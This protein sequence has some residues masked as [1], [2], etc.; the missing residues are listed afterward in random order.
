MVA[1]LIDAEVLKADLARL[2]S[3]F[4]KVKDIPCRTGHLTSLDAVE[5]KIA[6]LPDASE[7]ILAEV[8]RLQARVEALE[9]T[10]KDILAKEE[11]T[12]TCSFAKKMNACHEFGEA[13]NNAEA[14]LKEPK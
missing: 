1:K 10:L 13:L 3:L 12:R 11:K 9:T 4:E 5:R 14:L 6:E 7:P 2:R 8:T